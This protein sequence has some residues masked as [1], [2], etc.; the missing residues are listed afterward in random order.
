[1]MPP[2]SSVRILF[3]GDMHLGRLPSRVPAAALEEGGMDLRDIGPAATWKRI[4]AAAVANKVH[5]VALAG[6]LVERD[7]ALF[8]AYGPLA[9]GV[10][11]LVEEGIVVAGVAGN[12]DTGVLPRLAAEIDGF[13]LLGPGGTWSVLPVPGND[14][15]AVNL[16]GWSFPSRH[17]TA[18]P[19]LTAPPLPE[20]ITLGLLHADLFDAGSRY[21]PV[22]SADLQRVGYRGW[23]LGH[24]HKP[25][26]IPT[27]G[28]PFYLGSV[29]GLKPT[30]TGCHG[31]V[32]VQVDRGGNIAAERLP[33]ATLR[34]EERDLDC[35][36]LTDPAGEL[37]AHLLGE[38]RRLHDTLE[39]ELD[40]ARALGLRVVLTG[41]VDDP[42]AVE[43]AVR[44]FES[45]AAVTRLGETVLF[46]QKITNRVT[47]RIDLLEVANRSDP[48]G[49]LARQI[50]V[51]EDPGRVVTGVGD[52]TAMADE[53]VAAARRAIGTVDRESAFTPLVGQDGDLSAEQVRR[54]LARS[55]RLALA[56]LLAQPPDREAGHAAG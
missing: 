40:E 38:L 10:R 53:L 1:M 14:N 3:V 18:S 28:T 12:H 44:R 13:H 51:L 37:A 11:Q 4:V 6:D 9:T 56:G 19:L 27:D 36:R 29:T 16:A 32:L 46:V 7:N 34:W 48:P 15:W 26:P 8:E 39:V 22:K 35:S 31:P 21:A 25:D 42:A 41:E 55:G 24:I 43:K 33:L 5:A 49:L 17:H 50:L 52:P 2:D 23:F 20:G 30:E 47:A 54:M 45:G